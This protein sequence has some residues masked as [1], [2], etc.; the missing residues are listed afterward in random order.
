M[1]T[2]A[3]ALA[4]MQDQ[5]ARNVTGWQGLCLKA[6][7][8]AWGLPGGWEDADAW[9][10]ACPAEHRHPW[11]STP[12]PGAPVYWRI[13]AH[14]HVALATGDGDIYGTDIPTNDQVG[15]SSIN[16]P[17]DRWGATPVGWA[18]WLNGA[19]LPLDTDDDTPEDPDMPLSDDDLDKIAQRVWAYE[20]STGYQK[21]G[22]YNANKR[23]RV[24]VSSLLAEGA[25]SAANL[26]DRVFQT[27]YQKDGSY[28]SA[29]PRSIEPRNLLTEAQANAAR[30]AGD[31]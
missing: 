22:S 16:A 23:R 5:D 9:W 18:S 1:R 20:L 4:W 29:K 27:G 7:R 13:G 11:T 14:G 30:A 10:N 3:Q 28:N 6:S 15:R 25:A 26:W 12:P 2:A 17:R 21:D 8:S 24:S 19:A 31:L